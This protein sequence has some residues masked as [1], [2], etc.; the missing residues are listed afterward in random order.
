MSK[1]THQSFTNVAYGPLDSETLEKL[2]SIRQ[3]SWCFSTSDFT[4]V[5]T[6]NITQTQIFLLTHTHFLSVWQEKKKNIR[7]AVP[8]TAPVLRKVLATWKMSTETGYFQTL[9]SKQQQKTLQWECLTALATGGQ[10]RAMLVSHSHWFWESPKTPWSSS[11][12]SGTNKQTK[13]I[14]CCCL[15]ILPS[16][17]ITN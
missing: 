16:L 3:P 9:L 1:E 2:I 5:A 13:K 12:L 17:R 14:F 15:L 6:S 8:K 10:E 7:A 11:S 4:D